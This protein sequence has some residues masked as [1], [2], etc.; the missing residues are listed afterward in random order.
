MLADRLRHALATAQARGEPLVGVGP[1]GGGAVGAAGRPTGAAR[2]EQ[3]PVRLSLGVIDGAD[4]AGGP[5]GVL[6][7]A[8]EA[9]G[10]VAVAGLGDQLSPPLVAVTGSV[11]DLGEDA[12]EQLTH[13]NRVGHAAP[14]GAGIGGRTR[15][16]GACWASS[17]AGSAR[18]P[19]VAR[20]MAATWWWSTWG[21]RTRWNP[22]R[23]G[24]L[25][26]ATPT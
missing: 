16:P 17:P 15:S 2:L 21:V 25:V 3:H 13:A 11:D 7:P 6:D 12:G 24:R 10:V 18:S 5:V 23:P 1:V 8:G 22:G 26:T 19:A 9:D 4:L 20:M 14:S